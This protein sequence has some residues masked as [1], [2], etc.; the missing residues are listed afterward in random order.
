[1]NETFRH[2]WCLLDSV[3]EVTAEVGNSILTACTDKLGVEQG[4]GCILEQII[5]ETPEGMERR[6]IAPCSGCGREIKYKLTPKATV[7]LQES[8]AQET[9]DYEDK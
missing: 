5:Q 6:G 1:M 2:H 3:H 4:K 8:T 9:R 7:E